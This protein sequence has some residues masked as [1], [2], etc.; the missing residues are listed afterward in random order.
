MGL[1]AKALRITALTVGASLL[2]ATSAFADPERSEERTP[3]AK[4]TT[5]AR[6]HKNLRHRNAR[7]AILDRVADFVGDAREGLLA[8]A[9]LTR[10]DDR[11]GDLEE[12]RRFRAG[13]KGHMVRF[14]MVKRDTDRASDLREARLSRMSLTRRH[15]DFRRR[16]IIKKDL[17]QEIAL[18]KRGV[19]AYGVP[20]R[21]IALAKGKLDRIGSRAKK[22][23]K[24]RRK[25]RKDT[26]DREDRWGFRAFLTRDR[27]EARQESKDEARGEA[28]EEAKEGREE[29]REDAKLE[30][31]DEKDADRAEKA[32]ER[33]DERDS[34][35]N[36]DRE[37]D[38]TLT[39]EE[40]GD[41]GTD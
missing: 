39:K 18:Y 2:W 11:L 33:E 8:S 24:N 30:R 6:W 3:N 25:G 14:A 28:R 17:V 36:Q 10:I 13:Q 20:G 37:E 12:A 41:A 35:R 9:Q 7:Y 16:G 22:A 32:E 5:K 21:K 4:V 1:G 38:K 15:A 26:R 29:A 31:E 27:A 19:L 23:R 40:E 34:E